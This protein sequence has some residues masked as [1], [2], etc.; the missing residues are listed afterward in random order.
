MKG[1]RAYQMDGRILKLRYPSHVA[2]LA[3]QLHMVDIGWE[4]WDE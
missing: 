2:Q 4:E 3:S 1:I